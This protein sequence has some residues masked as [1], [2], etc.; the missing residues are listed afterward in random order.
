MKISTS[1]K[2][3][4]VVATL[5]V[6]TGCASTVPMAPKE[7][8]AAS[9]TFA[10]PAADQAGVY[11]YRNNFVGKA[12]KKRLMIDN[13]GIGETANGVYFHKTVTPGEHTLSTESEFGD[14][15][16]KFTAEGGKNY[17]FQQYIKMGVF[18]GGS[19]IQAVTEEVGK[20]NVLQCNEAK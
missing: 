8:D 4:V 14:N 18:V 13:V 9:K 2:T 7:Q 17:Y 3:L 6:L 5:A 1:L 12:L 11:I 19:G 20:Q 16:L 15:T 10:A